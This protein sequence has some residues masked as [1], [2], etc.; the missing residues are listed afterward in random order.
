MI[1]ASE[2][3]HQLE[4]EKQAEK[5]KRLVRVYAGILLAAYGISLLVCF[6]CN[7][8]VQHTLSW[9]FIA[10][11]AEAVAFSL[12]LTPVLCKKRRGL[13]T[14]GSLYLSLNF[15]LIVCRVQYGG[16]W[17]LVALLAVAMGFA[18]VF[19]PVVLR[20]AALPRALSSHKALVCLL[21]DTV[22]LFLLVTA[23]VC[24]TGHSALL[25]RTA[26]PIT[27]YGTLLPWLY[28][29]AI[30]Y[31]RVNPF[32]RVAV[33]TAGT[34]IHLFLLDSVLRALLNGVR[35]T[36]PAVH[37]GEW[38]VNMPNGNYLFLI[39]AICVVL[40]FVFV[41]GGVVWSLTRREVRR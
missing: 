1:T 26:Y 29:L 40:A 9:F 36:L 39:L 31:L 33:C 16:E 15:L 2:D 24:V 22:L 12:T 35:F 27:L 4:I 7:L 23:S 20:Q 11:A 3:L 41:V 34:G 28:L 38:G 37:L 8:A 19:L 6:I 18:A 32:F 13:W 17:L 10:L 21:A 5:W 30:R 14:F 25:L